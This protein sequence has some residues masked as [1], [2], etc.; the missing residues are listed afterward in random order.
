M[1]RRTDPAFSS[2]DPPRPTIEVAGWP[3]KAAANDDTIRCAILAGEMRN[4]KGDYVQAAADVFLFREDGRAFEAVRMDKGWALS[5]SDDGRI[6]SRMAARHGSKYD[7]PISKSYFA[8]MFAGREYFS[9]QEAEEIMRQFLS[10]ATHPASVSW[11]GKEG[12][13]M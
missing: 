7:R 6:I 12:A 5:I 2:L 4:H 9:W 13:S 11:V 1:T 10:S 8:R 3:A